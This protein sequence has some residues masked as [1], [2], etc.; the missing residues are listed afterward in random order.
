MA[1]T[2]RR[3]RRAVFHVA[4]SDP[5][6]LAMDPLHSDDSVYLR[7]IARDRN[8]ETAQRLRIVSGWPAIRRLATN[9][10]RGDF[11]GAR[12]GRHFHRRDGPTFWASA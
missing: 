11:T 4:L 2:A 12:G 10:V 3:R 7:F 6:K 1:A 9:G 5:A 8:R